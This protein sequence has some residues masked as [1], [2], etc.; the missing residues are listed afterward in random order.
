VSYN[1]SFI[2]SIRE[3]KEGFR[4]FCCAQCGSIVAD[5]AFHDEWHIHIGLIDKKLNDH[6][7]GSH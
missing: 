6:T 2:L 1:E 4:V 7:K 5:K 3:N